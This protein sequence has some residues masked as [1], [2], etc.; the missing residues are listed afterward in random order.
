MPN[1]THSTLQSQK[2]SLLIYEVG[3]ITQQS[4]DV[5]KNSVS[6]FRLNKTLSLILRHCKWLRNNN[7]KYRDINEW[8]LQHF[9]YRFGQ[10]VY[11][12]LQNSEKVSRFQN[13]IKYLEQILRDDGLLKKLGVRVQ[14]DARG[15]ESEKTRFF[16]SGSGAPQK[17]NLITTTRLD[18]QD[19]YL[20]GNLAKVFGRHKT[21]D[22]N[23]LATCPT[24][25]DCVAAQLAQLNLW[26]QHM[27][28][29]DDLVDSEDFI[30][31]DE[32]SKLKANLEQAFERGRQ[33]R[34][35]KELYKHS[36]VAA[37]SIFSTAANM[38]YD[39]GEFNALLK[40]IDNVGESTAVDNLASLANILSPLVGLF[41]EL[42]CR[43]DLQVALNAKDMEWARNHFDNL[44][45]IGV[46][47]TNI[48]K[49]YIHAT[50]RSK[51]FHLDVAED[52][53][54]FSTK[55]R[56]YLSVQKLPTT[57]EANCLLDPLKLLQA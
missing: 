43:I 19:L 29:V 40:M 4:Y 54:E 33:I 23:A 26:L 41:S 28:T 13:Q 57:Y 16:F 37:H 18:P 38:G 42:L 12:T 5:E 1:F 17:R 56:E 27:N 11:S 48:K 46:T 24:E 10:R 31:Y 34:L 53:R 9:P 7:E 3:V 55:M 44:S 2:D 8:E 51:R 47:D 35:K 50:A 32:Q 22:I 14:D 6:C 30:A 52:L 49:A 15:Y 45:E 21:V 20:V 39:E 25:S 36:T